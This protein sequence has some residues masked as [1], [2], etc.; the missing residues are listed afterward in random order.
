MPNPE[1]F[2]VLPA[3]LFPIDPRPR[4]QEAYETFRTAI[5]GLY[6]QTYSYLD[7]LKKHN[8][9]TFDHALATAAIASLS[10]RLLDMSEKDVQLLTVSAL[11]HD[12][13]KLGLDRELL[14][15]AK[16]SD[17]QQITRIR[18][19]HM[20]YA[21]A[22]IA[23]LPD[24]PDELKINLKQLILAHHD[25]FP[26]PNGPGVPVSY[27]RDNSRQA[28]PP[29]SGDRR[30]QLDPETIK[31]QKLLTLADKTERRITYGPYN[32]VSYPET[33][34]QSLRRMLG[35]HLTTADE[36]LFQAVIQASDMLFAQDALRQQ[37]QPIVIRPNQ[38]VYPAPA[39]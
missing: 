35:Q 21:R 6:P 27:P 3:D 22:I 13:G 30:T 2:E 33:V 7:Q 12:V 20:E 26:N 31:L 4:W 37:S 18:V 28:V 39:S 34:Q 29:A 25:I 1:K 11:L 17:T 16:P 36:P 19:G 23:S 38:P 24:C 9:L 8:Y 32:Q 14:I 15:N 10:A 5:A